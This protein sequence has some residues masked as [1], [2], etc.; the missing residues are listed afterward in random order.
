MSLRFQGLYKSYQGKTVLEK[1]SGSI[2]GKDKIGLIGING[3]GKTTL[4][5]I[6]AGE[7]TPDQG[8]IKLS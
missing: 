6:L 3:I 8:E 1:I 4:A 5:R 2:N 7:E